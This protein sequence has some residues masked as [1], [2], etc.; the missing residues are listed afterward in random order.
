MMDLLDML[1]V[2]ESQVATRQ[3]DHAADAA[4]AARAAK[5]AAD[6]RSAWVHSTLPNMGYAC[7]GNIV[8][9]LPD[10]GPRG[11]N[12]LGGW[13]VDRW[14]QITCPDCRADG[15][16]MLAHR[17]HLIQSQPGH[18]CPALEGIPAEALTDHMHDLYRCAYWQTLPA[19]PHTES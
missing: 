7:G 12:I 14:D 11:R 18:L 3:R 4:K 10:G 16:Q 1:G 13:S 5:D 6:P 9:G 8:N 17:A 19:G 2:D 15:L